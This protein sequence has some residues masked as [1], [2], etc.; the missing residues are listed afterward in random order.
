V[1]IIAD[2]IIIGDHRGW[3]SLSTAAIPAMCGA[4]IE[5]PDSKS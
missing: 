4:A 5:V 1:V 3:M 2:L